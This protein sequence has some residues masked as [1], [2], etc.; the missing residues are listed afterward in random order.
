[1]QRLIV[2]VLISLLLLGVASAQLK[3]QSKPLDLARELRTGV[4]P[5]VGGLLGLDPSRL[6]MSHS[7]SL[8]YF[9]LRGQS[10]AQGLYLNT[11]EYDVSQPLQLRL[12]W[13]IAHTPF[14]SAG[15]RSLGPTGP[16]VSGVQL[17]Y[18]PSSKF[19]LDVGYQALPFSWRQWAEDDGR[20][21]DPEHP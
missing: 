2:V 4:T 16:F 15:L 13:G 11:I 8:S 6:R 14:Q 9:S 7:Y 18:R 19:S 17:Q 3:E 1:M 20:R 21:W 5:G 10:M 12:Q